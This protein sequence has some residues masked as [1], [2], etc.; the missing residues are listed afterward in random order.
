MIVVDSSA[1]IEYYRA[2]G[3]R[4]VQDAVAAAIAAD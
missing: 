1:F 2:A 4:E 3:S